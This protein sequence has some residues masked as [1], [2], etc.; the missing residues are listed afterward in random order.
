MEV[1]LL[2]SHFLPLN[3]LRNRQLSCVKYGSAALT[4]VLGTFRMH[5]VDLQPAGVR[6]IL[7]GGADLGGGTR[8]SMF[9]QLVSQPTQR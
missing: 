3:V 6:G 4:R 5:L 1:I 7:F 9:P 8:R 2:L